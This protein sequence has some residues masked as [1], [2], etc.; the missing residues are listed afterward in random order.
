MNDRE[1]MELSQQAAAMQGN[2]K[3]RKKQI[4]IL[5]GI[6]LLLAAAAVLFWFHGKEL[7]EGKPTLSFRV[8]DQIQAADREEFTV[9]V[10]LSELPDHL[11]PAASVAIQFD[12]N[13][14]EFTGVKMGTMMIYDD[15]V[16]TEQEQAPLAIPTWSCNPQLAN[17]TGEIKA[18]YL[19]MTAEKKRLRKGWF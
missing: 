17:R 16:P 9:D 19:D 8:P 6:L 5:S 11:Y 15:C 3:K 1:D 7:L 4:L 10:V 18:M 14:L 2:S 13:K 12:K